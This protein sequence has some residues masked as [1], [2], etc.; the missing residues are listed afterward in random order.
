[1]SFPTNVDDFSYDVI[2]VPLTKE[3]FSP[4]FQATPDQSTHHRYIA[5]YAKHITYN[6]DGSFEVSPMMSNNRQVVTTY[7]PKGS[8]ESEQMNVVIHEHYHRVYHMHHHTLYY[9]TN[10]WVHK[11]PVEC[12]LLKKGS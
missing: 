8:Y 3:T 10:K 5:Y 6:P 2:E 1:M 12:E 7:A 4:D 11:K 9:A